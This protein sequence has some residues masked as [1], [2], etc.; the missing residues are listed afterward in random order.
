[1]LDNLISVAVRRTLV[2][3]GGLTIK[4]GD[5]TFY[6]K[7]DKIRDMSSIDGTLYIKVGYE[8]YDD[9]QTWRRM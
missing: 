1:M 5:R 7:N 8:T 9:Y 2:S 6:I 4:Q 3:L